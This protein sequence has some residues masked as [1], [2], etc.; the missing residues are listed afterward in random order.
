YEPARADA[1]ER[2]GLR[3]R[4][5]DKHVTKKRKQLGLDRDE[6]TGQGHA[7]TL[8]EGLP[9]HV[10]V[11][12]DRLLT[13][14]TAAGKT[15]TVMPEQ[16]ADAIALWILHSWQVNSFTI[17]PRLGI[18]SPTKGCGK[19]TV[20][21]LLQRL[22]CKPMR[23]GSISGPA[24]FRVVELLQ[25]TMLLDENEKYL[26]PGSELHA[27]LNEGHCKGGQVIRL[28]GENLHI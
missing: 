24:L 23:A 11:D 8:P 28:L 17:S 4:I 13:E 3:S 2:L 20:L 5:L 21:R 26:E 22:G 7:V 9:W 19:T 14:I 18:R 16:S 25:P 1:A 6:D 15:Y 27:L 10:P 12:G